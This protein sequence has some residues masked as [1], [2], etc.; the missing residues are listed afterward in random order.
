MDALGARLAA[1]CPGACV[2]H[3][4]GP[5]G[6]GKTTLVRGFL[7]GLGHTGRV[8][9]PS[10]S[11][12]EPYRVDGRDVIHADLYRLADPRELEF[13]GLEDLLSE[14]AVLLVEWPERGGERLPAP[15]LT[16][17]LSHAGGAR[18]VGFQPATEAGRALCEHLIPVS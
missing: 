2:I 11:L 4:Q 5:L 8:P 7:R 10:F 3:V 6:A 16:L 12:V 18:D 9:S 15:D 1:A 14:S 13:L 17:H